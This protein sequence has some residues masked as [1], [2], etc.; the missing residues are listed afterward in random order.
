MLY[1]VQ[2]SCH[3]SYCDNL[4]GVEIFN[5]KSFK[6]FK[7]LKSFKGFKGLKSLEGLNG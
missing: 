6:S 2:I 3:T 1:A 4:S 7:C 5:F